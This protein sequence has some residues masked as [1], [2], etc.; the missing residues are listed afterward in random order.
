MADRIKALAREVGYTACGITSARPFTDY[1]RALSDRVRRFPEA[2]E[3]Y[4][5]MR[6]R[7]DPRSSRKWARAVVACVRPYSKYA[8]PAGLVGH[9][10]R[11]YLFDL[12]NPECPDH[13]MPV[14]MKEG[15][16]ALGLRVR[17]GGVPDRLA[18]ARAGVARFGRNCFAIAEGG[19]W[20]NLETWMIDRELPVDAS[21]LEPPCPSNCDA[22]MR[23]CPTGAIVEPFVMRMDRCIA[24]L[25]YSAPQP[26]EPRLWERM[27]PWVYGC[28]ACQEACPLNH[29]VWEAR[30]RASW[31][32]P[33]AHLLTPAELARMDEETYREVVHP[34]FWYIPADEPERWRRN[35]R[36]ALDYMQ[37]AEGRET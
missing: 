28:D 30:E 29:G 17:K 1:R 20:V 12:R 21:T 34:R 4:E 16:R 2:A 23:A 15:L 37:K 32:D 9:I 33:I 7:V 27:G 10:G 18:A 5:P 24:Y 8:E 13:Q 35:A 22:C 31:L 6:G 36:R 11:N 3:L 26:I 19:S 25:T 14:R